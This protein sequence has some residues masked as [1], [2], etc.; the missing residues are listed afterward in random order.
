M[1]A[2]LSRVLARLRDERDE[3]GPWPSCD[4]CA[5][6]AICFGADLANPRWRCPGCC[7][8][9]PQFGGPHGDSNHL[10]GH[11]YAEGVAP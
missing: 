6:P 5:R 4:F 11:E 2:L 8:E 1:R 10:V 7:R 3:R 9:R